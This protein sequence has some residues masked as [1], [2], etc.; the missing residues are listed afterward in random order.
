[1]FRAAQAQQVLGTANIPAK[2]IEPYLSLF[3]STSGVVV[4]HTWMGHI[5]HQPL[6]HRSDV[7]VGEVLMTGHVRAG[8]AELDDPS[9]AITYSSGV[10]EVDR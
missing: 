10:A 2:S 6:T 7:C 8:Y 5:L 1:M 3:P 9:N 4:I